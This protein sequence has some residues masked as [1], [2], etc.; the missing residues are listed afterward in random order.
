MLN[1]RDEVL[2]LTKELVKIPSI[3][4]TSGEKE[5]LSTSF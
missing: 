5:K 4:N 2:A 3:V 1:C